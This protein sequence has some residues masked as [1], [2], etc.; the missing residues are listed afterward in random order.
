GGAGLARPRGRCGTNDP[1]HRRRA[2]RTRSAHQK[3]KRRPP[4]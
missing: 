4:M 3:S 1:P 2:M